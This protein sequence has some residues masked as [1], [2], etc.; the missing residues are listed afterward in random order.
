MSITRESPIFQ[1]T[2][3]L[4]EAAREFAKLTETTLDDRVTQWLVDS[5]EALEWLLGYVGLGEGQRLAMTAEVTPEA[6][7]LSLPH[8]GI[9]DSLSKAGISLAEIVKY[10]P[11]LLQILAAF[12]K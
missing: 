7:A 5:P 1:G 8:P 10:L 2:L 11:V 9:L 4:L 12:R 3:H 6:L